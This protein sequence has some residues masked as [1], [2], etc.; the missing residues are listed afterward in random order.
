MTCDVR[1]TLVKPRR[2]GVKGADSDPVDR[3][4]SQAI[5]DN[6]IYSNVVAAVAYLV[7]RVRL[8]GA[9]I[10]TEKYCIIHV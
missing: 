8:F 1:G 7:S 3:S 9:Q 4:R 6:G 10:Y 5:L 2:G